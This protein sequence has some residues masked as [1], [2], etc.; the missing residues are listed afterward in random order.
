VA[1]GC[2][3]APEE[4]ESTRDLI[5]KAN[6]AAMVITSGRGMAGGGRAH[7]RNPLRPSGR[8][9]ADDRRPVGRRQSVPV[10]RPRRNPRDDRINAPPPDGARSAHDADYRQNAQACQ[11]EVDAVDAD[12][13]AGLAK[14]KGGKVLAV[15]PVWGALC[16]RYGLVL[17]TPVENAEEK[18]SS[19]DFRA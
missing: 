8:A 9:G 7:A 10:A 2:R 16:A 1:G 3:A 4:L 19:A 18:L 6:R 15:R 14:W 11:A 5:G 17:V 12:M 13:R